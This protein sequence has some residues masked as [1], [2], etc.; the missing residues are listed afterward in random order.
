MSFK[1]YFPSFQQLKRRRFTLLLPRL[2]R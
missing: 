2:L 1:L